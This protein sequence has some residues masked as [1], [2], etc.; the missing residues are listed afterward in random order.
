MIKSMNAKKKIFALAIFI[1]TMVLIYIKS[2]TTK[3][4][5]IQGKAE[6]QI[7]NHMPSSNISP[8]K[9]NIQ[10]IKVQIIAI[11]GRVKYYGKKSIP[12]E[13][14]PSNAIIKETNSRGE[15]I[16]PLN[17]GK[18]TFFILKDNEAYKN[19]F[20]GNGYFTQTKVNKNTKDLVLTY[21]KFTIY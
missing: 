18:Y 14:I 7:G 9:K 21:D 11:P 4:I 20:D 19:N 2:T 6:I 15:F 10:H 8:Y 5:Q 13:Q 3:L 1:T 16:I 17:P 12:I